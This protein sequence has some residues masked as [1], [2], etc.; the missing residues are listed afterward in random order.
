ML[1]IQV[2][3]WTKSKKVRVMIQLL[4]SY[5]RRSFKEKDQSLVSYEMVRWNLVFICV[6]QI[7]MS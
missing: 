2:G 6:Y 1:S 3:L 4:W 5:D 7:S